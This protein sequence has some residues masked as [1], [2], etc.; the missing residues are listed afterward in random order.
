MNFYC[1]F[2]FGGMTLTPKNSLGPCTVHSSIEQIHFLYILKATY[3]CQNLN[4]FM[5]S[6]KLVCTLNDHQHSKCANLPRL[7]GITS[8]AVTCLLQFTE[9]L[10]HETRNIIENSYL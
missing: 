4:N 2:Y 8:T 9:V 1:Q 5:K 3:K 10:I 7:S 6:I